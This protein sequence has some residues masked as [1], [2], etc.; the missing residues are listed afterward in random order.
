MRSGAE[1]F[2][3]TVTLVSLA[4]PARAQGAAWSLDSLV[5]LSPGQLD[6]VYAADPAS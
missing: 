6:A 2:V 1:V 3:L 4:L 5:G